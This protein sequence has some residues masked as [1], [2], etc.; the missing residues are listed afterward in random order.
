MIAGWLRRERKQI[1][2]S[3]RTENVVLGEKLE[4]R[5]VLLFDEQRRKL[6]VK[7]SPAQRAHVGV[8]C[9][10]KRNGV[11]CVGVKHRR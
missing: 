2:E 1:I 9:A 6:A 5:R 3:L 8:S 11:T 4:K 10:R 7:G